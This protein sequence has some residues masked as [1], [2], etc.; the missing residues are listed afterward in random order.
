MIN[1][2]EISFTWFNR[3]NRFSPILS[4]SWWCHA[5][6]NAQPIEIPDQTGEGSGARV[7]RLDRPV[8]AEF[9][10]YT[11]YVSRIKYSLRS[12]LSVFLGWIFRS[13]L[14]VVLVF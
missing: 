6:L 3:V 8:R 1:N 10:N 4:P 2:I 11:L 5:S 13:Y 9:Q 12:F 7:N 14:T